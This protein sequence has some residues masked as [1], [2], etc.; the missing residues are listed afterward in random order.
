MKIDLRAEEITTIL[1]RQLDR[2]TPG[3]EPEEVGTVLSVGDGIA[4]VHGLGRVMSGE[5]LEFGEGG[6]GI[7]LNLE[8]DNVGVAIFGEDFRVKEGDTV[9]RTT[10]I[11][12]VPVATILVTPIASAM[13][14]KRR[15]AS[16]VR[17]KLS[18]RIAPVSAS[19]S[20]RRQ[21]DFSLKRGIG[22]RPSWS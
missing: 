16:R 14:R 22:A 1:R 13:A 8:E 21:S 15:V 6:P 9:R 17:R 3:M 18:G 10:R 20:P 12:S 4:H 7:A 19:F 2:F 5:M 11:A